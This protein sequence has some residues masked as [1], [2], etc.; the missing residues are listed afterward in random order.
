M[1][2]HVPVV[3]VVIPCFKQAHFLGEAIAS[4]L[5]QTFTDHEIIVVDDGSPDDTSNVVGQ[6]GCVKYIRQDHLGGEVARNRGIEESQGQY[7]VF[8]DADDRLLPHHFETSL[9]AFHAHPEVAFVCG[10]YRWIGS[11][12]TWHVHQ[13]TP[14][15][16]HYATLLRFNFI[17]PP[18][19]VMFR[20]D[21][22]TNIGG[23]RLGMRACQDQELYLRFAHRYPIYCHHEVVAEYRRHENQL[24]GNAA[25][26]L[27]MSMLM[28]RW[29]RPY[30]RGVPQYKEAYRF[31]VQF[32]QRLYGEILFWELVS[33]VKAG[34]WR[35]TAEAFLTLLRF[36]PRGLLGPIVQRLLHRKAKEII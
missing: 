3:S 24:T 36:H 33:A 27:R 26:M 11:D 23:F 12:D 5:A 30:I 16:D 13:C 14:L 4:V 28:L 19:V 6:Y 34:R 31:G 7:L 2:R 9:K 22:I 25:R 1:D 32:R 15:P 8:L 35:Q 29:Q 10:D 18:H 17:G 20:R 21:I